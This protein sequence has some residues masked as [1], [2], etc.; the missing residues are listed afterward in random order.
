MREFSGK[1]AV[2]TGAAS[3][4]GFALAER[5][6]QAG[7]KVVL[8]GINM[9]NIDKAVEALR[10]QGRDVLGVQT[11]VARPEAV[12]ELAQRT[13]DAYGKVHI[14]C[15]N[16][17]VATDNEGRQAVGE[18]SHPMWE[19]TAEDWRWAFDVN[20]FGVVNGIRTFV[21]IL[22][23]QGEEA[24]IVN[25]ASITGLIYA[26]RL[27]IYYTT[28]HAVVCLTEAL[29]FQ[30]AQQQAPI[31]VSVLCPA[32][33]ATRIASSAR[34]RPGA[35]TATMAEE[36]ERRDQAWAD[37]TR[38]GALNP[39]AVAEAVLQGIQAEQFYIL[40]HDAFGPGWGNNGI[41]TR[42]ENILARRNP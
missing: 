1:V 33:V 35:R 2:V 42:M 16:A 7:M 9:D 19:E 23:R 24:H 13:L 17:G 38:A 29:Y 40:P 8:A 10:C 37:A 26:R 6:A 11:D 21:P 39:E 25:S 34:N 14:V 41:R 32:N 4:I 3:G 18:H 31:H 22:L 5:F 20:L 15:N 12:D 30:L 28:K 27:P 36:F